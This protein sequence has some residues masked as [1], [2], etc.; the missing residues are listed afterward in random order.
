MKKIENDMAGEGV[1]KN[2]MSFAQLF[3]LSITSEIQF[4]FVLYLMVLF[5]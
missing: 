1:I 4:F 5:L 2:M 3:S